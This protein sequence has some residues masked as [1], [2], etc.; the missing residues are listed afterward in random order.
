MT[1]DVIVSFVHASRCQGNGRERAMRRP[2]VMEAVARLL[3]ASCVALAALPFAPIPAAASLVSA[4]GTTVVIPVVAQTGS[5]VSEILVHSPGGTAATLSV[6]FHEATGSATPGSKACA[7]VVVQPGRVASFGLNAQCSLGPGSHFGMLEIADAASPRATLVQAYSRT[8]NLQ[9]QGFSV[10]GYPIGA[11]S[12]AIGVVT[13]LRRQAAAP[14][15]QTNCFVGALSE[16]IEYQ[17]TLKSNPGSATLGTPITGTL[18]AWQMRRVLDVFGPAGVN[19]SAGDHSN[20][21]A[22]FRQ[23][24]PGNPAYVGFC[25]V[26]ESVTF[27]ADF[28]IARNIQADDQTRYRSLAYGHNGSGNLTTPAQIVA[29]GEKNVHVSN[30]RPPDNLRCETVGPNAGVLE[31]RAMTTTGV[32]LG[33]GSNSPSAA[34]A[35]GPRGAFS[36]AAP[37]IHFEVSVREGASPAYPVSYGLT[38]TSGN[39]MGWP[40]W[41]RRRSDDF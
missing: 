17:I 16:P 35:T 24:G 13:G 4:T 18:S 37:S 14:N 41:W 28:R 29:A 3:A 40:W 27:G 33:G 5:F 19:A 39:G 8:S 22:E 23:T 11:F 21:T 31:I 9:G 6:T 30:V 2:A 32:L 7:P 26:Q 25:T 15:Y 38:C 36:G 10:E 20:V 34:F 1:S 12:G